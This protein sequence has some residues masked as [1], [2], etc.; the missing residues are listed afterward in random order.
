MEQLILSALRCVRIGLETMSAC[1]YAKK[2]GFV[3][4]LAW[5][6]NAALE[7]YGVVAVLELYIAKLCCWREIINNII[8]EPFHLFF[9]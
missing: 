4:V 9:F 1:Y 5:P 3:Q 6:I 7:K 2:M 8:F